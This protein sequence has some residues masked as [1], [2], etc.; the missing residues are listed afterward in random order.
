MRG[1][2]SLE[3]GSSKKTVKSVIAEKQTTA[4]VT[5][6]SEKHISF[7]NIKWG[8]FSTYS[9]TFKFFN[10]SLHTI[11]IYVAPEQC[12]QIF[13]TYD[14]VVE[15]LKERYGPSTKSTEYYKYPYDKTDKYKHTDAIVSNEKVIMNDLW[16]FDNKNTPSEKEDDDALQVS[17][18]GAACIVMIVYQDTEM[19]DRVVAIE[20]N[21]NSKDY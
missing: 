5:S 11:Y 16:M 12:H 3:F 21:K 18:K 15:A 13:D 1:A 10:D 4:K 7:E 9:V 17:I 8:K 19:I 20:K 14:N 2:L 6:E